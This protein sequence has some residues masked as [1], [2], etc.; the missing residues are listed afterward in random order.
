MIALIL[1]LLLSISFSQEGIF[2]AVRSGD[3]EKIKRLVK[4]E[5]VNLKDFE[6]ASLLHVAAE[7]SHTEVVRFLIDSGA[8][9]NAKN[10]N[11]W[12]PLHLAARN[13]WLPGDSQVSPV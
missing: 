5:N 6:G 10:L 2:E 4:K 3:L 7:F 1:V 8:D 12:T 11:G 13:G 9:V